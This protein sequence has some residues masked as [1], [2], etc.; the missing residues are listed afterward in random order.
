MACDSKGVYGTESKAAMCA[1]IE[2]AVPLY[3]ESDTEETLR[4]AY[5]FELVLDELC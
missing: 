1:E 2:D 5:K 3:S 4:Q